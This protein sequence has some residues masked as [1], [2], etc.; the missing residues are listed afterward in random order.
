MKILIVDDSEIMRNLIRKLLEMEG[1]DNFMEADSGA[2]AMLKLA[3]ADL[4]LTDLNMPG[5]NGA[6]L[7]REIR[8]S[9]LYHHMPICV[10]TS[11]NNVDT[12]ENILR[13]GVDDY[14]AKPFD[15]KRL[16]QKVKNLEEKIWE[17]QAL[18]KSS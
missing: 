7:I 6:L 8:Q 13:M 1:Y 5:M 10:I 17:R 18:A 15:K 2:Q 11:Q 9:D 4:V 12:V 3:D 14:I 16:I